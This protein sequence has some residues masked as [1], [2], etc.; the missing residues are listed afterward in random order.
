MKL[1]KTKKKDFA[2]AHLFPIE[3]LET[4]YVCL[5]KEQNPLKLGG[6]WVQFSVSSSFSGSCALALTHRGDEVFTTSF[7][8]YR[9]MLVSTAFVTEKEMRLKKGLHFSFQTERSTM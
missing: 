7:S 9:D 1:N 6:R 2:N 4:T 5:R 8:E 3:I